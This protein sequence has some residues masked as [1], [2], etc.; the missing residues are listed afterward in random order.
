MKKQQ[1]IK[2]QSNQK[3]TGKI[4]VFTQL[5]FETYDKLLKFA[6]NE[7]RSK[8]NAIAIIVKRFLNDFFN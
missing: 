4:P 6:K 2:N 7:N 5:D 3:V 1:Q 8:G